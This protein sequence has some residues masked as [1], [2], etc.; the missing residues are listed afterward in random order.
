M[1]ISTSYAKGI[2]EEVIQ[3]E[4]NASKNQENPPV[5]LG[6]VVKT[7][8]FVEVKQSTKAFVYTVDD[9]IWGFNPKSLVVGDVIIMARDSSGIPIAIDIVD[10]KNPDPTGHPVGEDMQRNI[11]SLKSNTKSW[12]PYVDTKEMLPP[13]R[14]FKG[15]TRLVLDENIFYTWNESTATWVQ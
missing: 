8:P 14:N 6:M 3:A 12:K 5:D 11:N 2:L 13:A 9:I 1:A 10:A 4:V 15:D 7:A